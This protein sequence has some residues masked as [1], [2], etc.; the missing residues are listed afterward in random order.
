[1]RQ[2]Q[3]KMEPVPTNILEMMTGLWVSQ[4]MYVTTELGIP[5]ELCAGPQSADAIA[6]RVDANPDAWGR[7]VQIAKHCLRTRVPLFRT[8]S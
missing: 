7:P 3:Q 8:V 5:D 1:L 2:H 4:A 6:E